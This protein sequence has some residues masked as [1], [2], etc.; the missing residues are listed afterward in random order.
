EAATVDPE[1]AMILEASLVGLSRSEPSRIGWVRERLE[2]H[3]G[4][5][6][7]ATPPERML[8]ATQAHLDAFSRRSRA[9]AAELAD[10]AERALAGGRLLEDNAGRGSS[11]FFAVDVLLLADRVEPARRA[12]EHAIE[13]ARRRGSAPA[14]A[15][16]S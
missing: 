1:L 2:R 8:L 11:F 4:R 13:D 16:A 9:P 7:G 14:F 3:R 12:L 6:T 10:V 15:F 5:L